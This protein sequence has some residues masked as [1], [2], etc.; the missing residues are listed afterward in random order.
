MNRKIAL[1]IIIILGI[2]IIFRSPENQGT[3][4]PTE[5]EI[6]YQEENGCIIKNYNYKPDSIDH[7]SR[8]D[9]ISEY[10]PQTVEDCKEYIPQ[11]QRFE[12]IS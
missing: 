10:I 2:I 6:K 12:V 9:T 1:V 7:K 8:I 4:K 11:S 3:P 5:E